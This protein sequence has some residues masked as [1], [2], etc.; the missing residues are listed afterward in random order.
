MALP[1][2]PAGRTFGPASPVSAD[3]EAALSIGRRLGMVR[4][5]GFTSLSDTHMLAYNPTI[6]L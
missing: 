3:A 4:D 5:A 1:T 2:C 6:G